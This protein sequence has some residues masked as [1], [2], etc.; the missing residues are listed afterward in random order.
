[1]RNI[2]NIEDAFPDKL[3]DFNAVRGSWNGLVA[4]VI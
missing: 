2:N 3:S 4:Q 1:M